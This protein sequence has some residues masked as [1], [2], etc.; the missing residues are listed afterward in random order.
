MGLWATCYQVGGIV[1]TGIAVR[2]L[3]R[4]GWRG[5]FI[6]PAIILAAVGVLVLL[7]L[8]TPTRAEPARAAGTESAPTRAEEAEAARTERKAAQRRVL[9]D[10]TIWFYGASYFCI[11]LIRYSFLLWLPFYLETV[12][13]YAKTRAADLSTSFEIGGVVGTIA[14]GFVS[15]RFRS[16]RRSV[17][18]AVSLVGLAGSLY[19]YARHGPSSAAANFAIMA[20]VG[21]LLFG[22]DALLAGAAAQDVG[23]PKAAAIAAG[24]INC[25][26]SLGAVLQELVTRGVSGRY[27]WNTLFYVFLALALLGA[28]CLVPTFRAPANTTAG[29]LGGSSG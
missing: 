20:L 8:R 25:L 12:L 3:V 19:L 2:L 28:A 14:I 6:G 27:G 16:V 24:I 29:D 17:F 7:L 15:D 21:A 26:G 13:G 1:A 23:G 4:Y 5:A 11:K 22:P 9:R 10:P 18:A